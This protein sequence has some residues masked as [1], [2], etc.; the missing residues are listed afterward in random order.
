MSGRLHRRIRQM[1]RIARR[2]LLAIVFPAFSLHL[3][4]KEAEGQTMLAAAI[5]L[6]LAIGIF[7]YPPIAKRIER[8]SPAWNLGAFVSLAL[9]VTG[10]VAS[11]DPANTWG[12]PISMFAL[13][14]PFIHVVSKGLD[15]EWRFFKAAQKC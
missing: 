1:K 2:L 11:L 13:G 4:W 12:W 15:N 3:Y 8:W 14:I 5:A 10:F 6:V 9:F 7:L